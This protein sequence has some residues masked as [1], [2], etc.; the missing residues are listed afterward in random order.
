M[1]NFDFKTLLTDKGY[2]VDDI[3]H[4]AKPSSPQDS[5]EKISE[6]LTQIFI[7]NAL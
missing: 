6:N 7:K 3:L 2:D 4:Y 5:C 1:E